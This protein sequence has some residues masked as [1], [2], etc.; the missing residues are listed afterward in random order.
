VGE[1][2]QPS[3]HCV[4]CFLFPLYF[5]ASDH[6]LTLTSC[7]Y[8]LITALYSEIFQTRVLCCRTTEG[9]SPGGK[10][11]PSLFAHQEKPL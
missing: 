8:T 2:V 1:L 9:D 3:K 11:A 6:R 5:A 7:P 10:R 4:A